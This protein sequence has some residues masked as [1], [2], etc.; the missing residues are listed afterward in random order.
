[1]HV[2]LCILFSQEIMRCLMIA[3]CIFCKATVSFKL[4]GLFE[5]FK[6]IFPMVA[7][8]LQVNRVTRGAHTYCIWTYKAAKEER[9]NFE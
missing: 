2:I 1:M 9:R 6:S 5:L 7:A 8:A 4:D 3:L